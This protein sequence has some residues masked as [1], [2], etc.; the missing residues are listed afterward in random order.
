MISS[1]G[2]GLAFGVLLDAFL[3]RMLL[4]PAV[5]HLA[6]DAAWWLPKWLERV[7]PDVDVEGSALERAHLHQDE[8]AEQTDEDRKPTETSDPGPGVT[9]G[10]H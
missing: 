5:M 4:I 6:G 3:V 8:S 9:S 2:F 1:V 7:L 10:R